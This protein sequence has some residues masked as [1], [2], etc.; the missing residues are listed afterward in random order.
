M[1]SMRKYDNTSA[2]DVK[3][4]NSQFPRTLYTVN[5]VPVRNTDTTDSIMRN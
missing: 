3:L 4:G 2:A 1:A 5:H